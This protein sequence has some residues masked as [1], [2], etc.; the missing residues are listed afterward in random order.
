MKSLLLPCAGNESMG[1]LKMWLLGKTSQP[2][3]VGDSPRV[4]VLP[5]CPFGAPPFEFEPPPFAGAAP[6]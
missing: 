1:V 4:L 5:A 6:P 2:A 3:T